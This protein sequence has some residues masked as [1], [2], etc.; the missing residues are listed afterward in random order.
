MA[1]TG[2]GFEASLS[3]VM[4]TSH[5]GKSFSPYYY[6]LYTSTPI[7][8]FMEPDKTYNVWART[9]PDWA[10]RPGSKGRMRLRNNAEDFLL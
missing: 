8:A 3:P 10:A 4:Q 5:A 9:I 2:N 7:I 6:I 1:S